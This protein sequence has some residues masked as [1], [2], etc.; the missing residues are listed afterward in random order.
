MLAAITVSNFRCHLYSFINRA[1]LAKTATLSTQISRLVSSH[2]TMNFITLPGSYVPEFYGLATF[3]TA[4][5]KVEH[6]KLGTRS[7]GSPGNMSMSRASH[8][9]PLYWQTPPDSKKPKLNRDSRN[10][11]SSRYLL[12]LFHISLKMSH[13]VVIQYFLALNRHRKQ[14]GEVS[15][16]VGSTETLRDVKLQVTIMNPCF[17]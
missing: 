2:T 14:R 12:F 9:P 3:C 6:C 10:R 8:Q 11:R 4:R 15:L 17:E 5:S 7:L 1:P 13:F 16:T